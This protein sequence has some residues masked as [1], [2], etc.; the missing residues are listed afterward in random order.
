MTCKHKFRTLAGGSGGWEK[1]SIVVQ[2]DECLKVF[3]YD[4]SYH[5]FRIV[6]VEEG[7]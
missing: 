6:E 2:C 1:T 5:K 3:F 4:A 7:Q